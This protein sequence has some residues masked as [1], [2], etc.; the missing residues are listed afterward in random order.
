MDLKELW[1]TFAK[2]DPLT[3]DDIKS[4]IKSAESAL[5]YLDARRERF[6]SFKTR[7]DLERL[8]SYQT[9]R[10]KGF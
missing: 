6:V 5:E 7:L 2:G 10:K 8:R 9:A 4:L 1:D 3:D